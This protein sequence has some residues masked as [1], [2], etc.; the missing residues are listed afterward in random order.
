MKKIFK[1]ILT[2][3]FIAFSALSF[4]ACQE[5]EINSQPEAPVNIKI[6][7]MEEYTILAKN[8]QKIVF[9]VSSNTPW[10]ITSDQQ[11]CTVTP[12]MSAASSLVSEIMVTCEPN[13]TDQQRVATLTISAKDI[14]KTTTV[15][16]TQVSKEKLVVIPYD[17]VVPTEGG[18]ISFKLVSNKPWTITPSTMFVENIDKTSGEGNESGEPEV[19]TVTIPENAGALRKG[20]ITVTTEFDEQSFEITQDGVII[21]PE[22]PTETGTIDFAHGTFEKTIKI[23]SNQEWTVDV[24]EEY[25]SWISAE[26]LSTNELKITTGRNPK[27]VTRKAFVLLKTVNLIPGFE[28]IELG[29]TQ[30]PDFW[31]DARE[32]TEVDKAT[33]N[34]K[35]YHKLSNTINSHYALKKGSVAFEFEE[36]NLLEKSI[37]E[38]NFWPEAGNTNFHFYLRSDEKCQVTCGGGF[39]WEQKT[40]KLSQEEVNS[41]RKV[42]FIVADDPVNVGKLCIKLL[43]D[44][45]EKVVLSNKT[46]VYATEDPA[47]PGQNIHLGFREVTDGNYF[48]IKSITYTPAE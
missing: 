3:S 24:P 44:G 6:D 18:T 20:T 16:L 39:P 2:L 34:V 35:I 43:L 46:N 7:A 48:V 27:V 25:A 13:N 1:T 32:N 5:Y 8:P 4:N 41:I 26:K 9:N 45:V 36:L 30:A 14:E 38:F 22:E 19:I 17:E 29:V 42:E 15:K 31:L 47:N 37:L 40:F 23:R 12:S 21:E 33:G 11:W 28:G 10:E